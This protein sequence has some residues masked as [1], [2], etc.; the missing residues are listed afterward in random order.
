[1][2]RNVSEQSNAYI[3]G[4]FTV[5]VYFSCNKIWNFKPVADMQ[6]FRCVIPLALSC[7]YPLTSL[8]NWLSTKKKKKKFEITHRKI[9]FINIKYINI[10]TLLIL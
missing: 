8:F 2:V 4:Y 3:V 1:M 6:M 7:S 9:Q 5:Q 10:K